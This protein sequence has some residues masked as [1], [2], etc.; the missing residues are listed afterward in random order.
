MHSWISRAWQLAPGHSGS[1]IEG[2]DHVH[3]LDR[4]STAATGL[5]INNNETGERNYSVDWELKSSKSDNIMTF[6]KLCLIGNI[7]TCI[8]NYTLT[9][10]DYLN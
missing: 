9:T 1:T 5:P 7:R 6:N 3:C 8:L 2:T 4:R 10:C